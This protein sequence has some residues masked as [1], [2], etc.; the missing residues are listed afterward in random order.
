MESVIMLIKDN[1]TSFITLATV[2][3][4]I[5]SVYLSL[6]EYYR[7]KAKNDFFFIEDDFRK[8]MRNSFHPE[9]LSFSIV[10]LV[11][12]F[13][14]YIAFCDYIKLENCNY[15][16]AL[17]IVAITYIISFFF[18]IIVFL[19]FQ[20]S[21]NKEIKIWHKNTYR[22]NLFL[23]ASAKAGQWFFFLAFLFG[24]IGI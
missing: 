19:F 1:T 22:K 15:V 13:T 17:I 23:S 9:Y 4:S 20:H 14:F 6:A 18:N 12:I 8:P 5:L 3:V 7:V 21:N 16:T 2:F 24:R 11:L 10:I